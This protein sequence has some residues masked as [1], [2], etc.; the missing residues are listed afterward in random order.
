M[1]H[2]LK[3]PKNNFDELFMDI[4][5]Y[6]NNENNPGETVDINYQK[7]SQCRKIFNHKLQVMGIAPTFE[8]KTWFQDN[9]EDL[10]LWKFEVFPSEAL[11]DR[12]VSFRYEGTEVVKD[13]VSHEFYRAIKNYETMLF[14]EFN[15]YIIDFLPLPDSEDIQDYDR[16]NFVKN[17]VSEQM[18]YFRILYSQIEEN[19]ETDWEQ[20]DSSPEELIKNSYLYQNRRYDEACDNSVPLLSD[21]DI[22]D[23]FETKAALL[24]ESFTVVLYPTFKRSVRKRYM[25][26]HPSNID[27]LEYKCPLTKEF[28]EILKGATKIVFCLKD[29]EVVDM[30]PIY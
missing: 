13:I 11:N 5:S 12:Y 24:S 29:F 26:L 2:F 20:Y 22:A 23:Y 1:R 25:L 15:G 30:I 4:Q 10:T 28:F 27:N 3:Y 17:L 7:F 21:E 9:Y 18:R 16:Y 8:D 6:I 14:I 19:V